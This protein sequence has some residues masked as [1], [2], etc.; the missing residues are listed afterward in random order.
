[1][2]VFLAS[3][4][5]CQDFFFIST[6]KL[7]T[8]EKTLRTIEN[9]QSTS[10]CFAHCTLHISF[11]S[12]IKQTTYIRKISRPVSRV[13]SWMVIYLGL[14]LPTAS[15]DL[16]ESK[17]GRLI[18]FVLVLLRM[19][20]TCAPVVTNR[21]V[22]SYTALPPLPKEKQNVFLLAVY[23]CCTGLGVAST[24]RYPASCPMKPGL[25]SSDTCLLRPSG[26]LIFAIIIQFKR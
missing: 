13:M 15:S 3:D 19:G 22:V 25:S 1:M 24:G 18:A 10:L 2:L 12:A 9:M 16:P 20:F 4:S 26:L 7:S 21:A 8:Y 23:F 17:P 6:P 11:L 5:R 14:L